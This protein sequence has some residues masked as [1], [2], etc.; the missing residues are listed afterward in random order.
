MEVNFFDH[1]QGLV[2]SSDRFEDTRTKESKK[3]VES[4]GRSER[5]E[6]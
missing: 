5:V 2:V 3:A 6:N 4:S 1:H